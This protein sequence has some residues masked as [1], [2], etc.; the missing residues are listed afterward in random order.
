MALNVKVGLIGKF[1]MLKFKN[2]SKVREKAI[3]AAP[4]NEVSGEFA[5]NTNAK[6][7]HPDY[8]RL[9]IDEVIPHEGAKAKT[10]VFR[11]ADGEAFPYFRAGQY[12]SLK[13]PLEDSFVTRAY[14]LCSSPKD[15]LKGRAAITVRSNPGGFAA[16]KLL[17]ALKPGDEVIAS[18]PQGFFYYEDLR[19]AKHVVGLAGGSG[20]TPFLS[21]AYALRDGAEDFELTLLYGSRDEESIL[22][23]KELDEVAAACPKFRVVHVLSDEEK[24]GYEHGF[25]T[26]ELI[27]KYAPADAEYSVFLC[28]PEGMYR[29]L[30][31]EIEKLALPERLFRRKMIDVTKTP[32]ELDGYPQQCRDKIF[33]LTVRQGDREYK[34]SASANE[35]VLTAIERAGIKAPS[36]CRSGECGWCRSRMLEG[37]V[38]IPQ[39]NELRRWADKE[40][41]YIHPC[42]SFPTSDIVLEVPSEFY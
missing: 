33:N 34:L 41:G 2:M 17:A 38:F 6:K 36:R 13:L 39:E 25:I 8:Q 37:S 32:W 15:A 7:L 1:D 4:A 22:F 9:V 21:M 20:I 18:D 23:K 31:P 12:L 3:Q 5:I 26:A 10:F 27:K 19:D 35:T 16:D 14:S 11:R 42:S 30:K 24:A 28:G 29:F 40:Y